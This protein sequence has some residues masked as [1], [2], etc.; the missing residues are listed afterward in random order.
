VLKSFNLTCPVFT[1]MCIVFFFIEFDCNVCYSCVG[2]SGKQ[3]VHC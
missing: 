1:L 2:L 3:N